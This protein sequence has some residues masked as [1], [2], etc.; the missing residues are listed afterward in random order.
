MLLSML[1]VA[2]WVVFAIGAFAS[3]H[4]AIVIALVLAS[5]TAFAWAT[6]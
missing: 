1:Y 5:M 6:K 2:G 4:I 3:V